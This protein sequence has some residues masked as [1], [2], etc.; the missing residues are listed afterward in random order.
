MPSNTLSGISLDVIADKTLDVLSSRFFEFSQFTRDFSDDIKEKGESVKTRIP[1]SVAA[2]NLDNGFVAQNSATTEKTILLNQYRGYVVG[3][4]DKEVSYAGNLEWLENIL[5]KPAINATIKKVCDDVLALVTSTAFPAALT[6]T[7]TDFDSDDLST[8][9]ATLSNNKVPKSLRSALI[10]FDYFSSLQKD[11]LHITPANAYGSPEAI[12]NHD[13]RLVHGIGVTGY[14][15]IPNNGEN[16]T[17]FVCHPSALLIAARTPALPTGPRVESAN[18]VT[19]QGLPI[20]IRRWY[21]RN[22]GLYKM[23]IGILY[24]VQTGNA[25]SLVRIKSS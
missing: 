16:L 22:L 21:S 24:G 4:K 17:G 25:S 11:T 12:Q 1:G 19:E 7:A 5:I 8:A 10:G 20:Q 2:V 23:S 6:V 14:E 13:A 18:R 3:L 15:G 9:A